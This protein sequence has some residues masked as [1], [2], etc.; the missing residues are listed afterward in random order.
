MKASNQS[1]KPTAPLPYDVS[2]CPNNAFGFVTAR[3]N[4]VWNFEEGKCLRSDLNEQPGNHCVRDRD[5][6]NVAPL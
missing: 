3:T 6:V 2:G 1:M 4:P 5:L